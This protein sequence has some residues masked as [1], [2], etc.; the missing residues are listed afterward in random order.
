MEILKPINNYKVPGF[1]PR[2][3]VKDPID[4]SS[5]P[6]DEAVHPRPP[7]RPTS[8]HDTGL[9]S[10]PSRPMSTSS[11]SNQPSMPQRRASIRTSL[12]PPPAEPQKPQS[13]ASIVED[14]EI[15]QEKVDEYEVEEEDVGMAA[16]ESIEESVDAEPQTE[17]HTEE[18]E[19]VEET[20]ILGEETKV[21]ETT[22]EIDTDTLLEVEEDIETEKV[23]EID[24]TLPQE[25]EALKKPELPELPSGPRLAQPLRPKPAKGRR[26]PS[27]QTIKEAGPS[28]TTVL[29]DDVAKV[30]N[31]LFISFL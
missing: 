11:D 4:D 30:R 3:P 25:D 19:T 26:A 31:E 18:Q 23:E 29:E 6:S 5:A 9:S 21:T 8:V 24:D 20:T 12:P 27:E 10:P 16:T 17:V 15:E 14:E 28:Q 7:S 1:P 2:P 22:K 13:R